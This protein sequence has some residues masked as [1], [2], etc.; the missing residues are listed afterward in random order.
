MPQPG[1]ALTA[2]TTRQKVTRT[3]SLSVKKDKVESESLESS[4]GNEERMKLLLYEQIP[5]RRLWRG[6]GWGRRQQGLETH[7]GDG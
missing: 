5:A 2:Q 3:Q 4:D 6:K 7:G 1:A